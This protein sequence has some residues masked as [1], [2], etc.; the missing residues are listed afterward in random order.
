MIQN[1]DSLTGSVVDAAVV[2]NIAHSTQGIAIIDKLAVL[3]SHDAV[4][5]YNNCRKKRLE[6]KEMQ[7][8][9]SFN[10]WLQH[11][12]SGVNLP[13][14][15]QWLLIPSLYNSKVLTTS[16]SVF[17]ISYIYCCLHNSTTTASIY[18][19]FTPT[20]L[21][22]LCSPKWHYWTPWPLQGL[23]SLSILCQPQDIKWNPLPLLWRRLWRPIYSQRT[24]EM[25]FQRS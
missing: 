1:S 20:Y 7:S 24:I 23:P 16:V 18:N 8:R 25:I 6:G 17:S 3:F 22:Q 15:P 13:E 10:S 12:I 11:P 9:C 19:K 2:V 21:F 5:F 14:R 4:Q